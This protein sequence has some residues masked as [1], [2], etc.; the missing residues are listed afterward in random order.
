MQLF[1]YNVTSA[2]ILYNVTPASYTTRHF[3]RQVE[4]SGARKRG[5]GHLKLPIIILLQYI[6]RSSIISND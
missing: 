6:Q 4:N 5:V 3:G 1:L 2:V